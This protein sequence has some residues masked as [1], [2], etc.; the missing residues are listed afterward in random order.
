MSGSEQAA[1]ARERAA[2]AAWLAVAT[3][4]EEMRH[5][6]LELQRQ[7]NMLANEIEYSEAISA[8]RPE[9]QRK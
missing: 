2:E 7:W 4:N 8:L 1:K 6:Y 5:A 9:R 3:F